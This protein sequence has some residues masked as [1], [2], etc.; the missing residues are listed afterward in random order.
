VEKIKPP[1]TANERE[2][3]GFVLNG[4]KAKGNRHAME[5][6]LVMITVEIFFPSLSCKI[7]ALFTDVPNKSI[8]AITEL[9]FND[10]AKIKRQRA[11]PKKLGGTADK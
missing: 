7:I 1:A 10:E 5:L 3:C 2:L 9:M 4:S 6:T 11:A 8:K